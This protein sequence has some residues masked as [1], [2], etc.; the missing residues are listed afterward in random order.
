[1]RLP[2]ELP[3]AAGEVSGGPSVGNTADGTL[4]PRGACARLAGWLGGRSA[5]P[6]CGCAAVERLAAAL[7]NCGAVVSAARASPGAEGCATLRG[8]PA[9]ALLTAVLPG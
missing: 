1:M 5:S 2:A 7:G 4:I 6:G 3:A 9:A 8:G